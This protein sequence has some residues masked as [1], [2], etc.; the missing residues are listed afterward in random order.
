MIR[1]HM[2]FEDPV[3]SKTVVRNIGEYRVGRLGRRA[4]G[5]HIEVQYRIDY[6]SPGRRRVADHV[7]DC[8][9]SF[10]EKRFYVW[11]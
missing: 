5:G 6:Y 10:V 7:S 4:A 3:D 1:V 11:L 8:E 2:G 9:C